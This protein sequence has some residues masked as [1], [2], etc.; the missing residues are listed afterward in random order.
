[1]RGRKQATDFLKPDQQNLKIVLHLWIH[2][3]SHR[4]GLLLEDSSM[5]LAYAVITN[6]SYL[7]TIDENKINKMSK[8]VPVPR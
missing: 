2:L 4:F 7:K 8:I 1:M 6:F 3:S 5:T